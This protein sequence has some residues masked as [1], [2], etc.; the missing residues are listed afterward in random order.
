MIIMSWPGPHKPAG[1]GG[2][3]MTTEAFNKVLDIRVKSR[4][5]LFLSGLQFVN[6][7]HT[8]D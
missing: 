2:M 6:H 1:E 4:Q 7:P 5:L 8:F 3:D